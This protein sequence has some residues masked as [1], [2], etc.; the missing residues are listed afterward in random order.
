LH[1]KTKSGA[2]Q[3]RRGAV[4]PRRRARALARTA[5]R[6]MVGRRGGDARCVRIGRAGRWPG[7]SWSGAR[8][9]GPRAGLGVC[10]RRRTAAAVAT[11]RDVTRGAN[12]HSGARTIR[13][14][15]VQTRFSPKS[16]TKVHQ[17]INNKVVDQ[18]TLYHFHK[19]RLAFFSIIF[20]QIGCQN[21]E[22]LGS[23]E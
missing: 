13:F 15:R 7:G 12:A 10:V 18:L 5:A 16:S 9:G 11:R 8:I 1:T 23:S 14:S 21:A 6:P 2:V 4:T 20:A 17:A 22:F 19:G 3:A